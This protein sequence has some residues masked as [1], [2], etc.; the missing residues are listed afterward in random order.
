MTTTAPHA[1]HLAPRQDPRPPPSRAVFLPL[2][3]LPLVLLLLVLLAGCV[4]QTPPPAGAPAAAP[5]PPEPAAAPAE[6]APAEGGE[7]AAPDAA[8]AP[9]PPAVVREAWETERRPRER[10][11]A[12]AVWHGRGDR[13]WLLATAAGTDRLLVFD[14]ESGETLRE[15]GGAGDGAGRFRAPGALDVVDD[16]AFV[17]ERGNARVQVLRLPGLSTAGYVG[18]GSLVR[19][20][21][22]AVERSAAGYEVFV[23]E[24]ADTAR[25]LRHFRVDAASVAGAAADLRSSLVE[26]GTDDAAPRRRLRGEVLYPCGDGDGYRLAAEPGDGRTLFRVHR[27]DGGA[28]VGRF[29]GLL[30]AGGGA[31]W[32]AT[33]PTPTFPAGALYAVHDAAS[34]TVFDWRHLAA[35][36]G[37]R[38]DCAPA[39]P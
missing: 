26:D 22:L 8:P 7:A 10:L 35:V 38:A 16:L 17:L 15:F 25:P 12:V 32:L 13:P 39:P 9:P 37:L 6:T 5:P 21:G 14:A 31:L 28:E 24:A 3:L 34:V 4:G 20:R 1:L 23:G 36:L 11:A 2:V 18:R 29:T 33:A 30:T 19:P 27:L